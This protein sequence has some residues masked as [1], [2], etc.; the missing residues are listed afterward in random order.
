VKSHVSPVLN[1]NTANEDELNQPGISKGFIAVVTSN[2]GKRRFYR[3]APVLVIMYT[4]VSQNE[5]LQKDDDKRSSFC[6]EYIAKDDQW[7]LTPVET[8]L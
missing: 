8:N 2:D 7:K 5:S 1:E 3:A 6:E 4:I